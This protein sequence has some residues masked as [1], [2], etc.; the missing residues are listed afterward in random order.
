LGRKKI[1]QHLSVYLG[2]NRVGTL[3]KQSNGAIEF[4]YLNEWVEK[5]Y[6]IS[7]SLPL[8]DKSFVGDRASF[9][10][11]NLLPDNKLIVDAIAKKVGAISTQQFDLLSAIGR[12]CVGAL[13]FF[14]PEEVPVYTNKMSVRL[15]K[16][17]DI[18]QR[19]RGLTTDTPLGMEDGDFRLSLAGVQEKMALL[20][21]KGKWFEPRGQTATSHILKKKMGILAGGISFEKSVDNEWSCLFLAKQVGIK[22]CNAEIVYFEDQRVLSVERFDRVWKDNFLYR[23]PQEDLCQA[24]GISPQLKYERSGKG[25]SIFQIM[26]ILEH[27]NNAQEDRK[28]FFKTVLFNDLIYNT[29]GHAKNFSIYLTKRGFALTPMYDLL[30]AHFMAEKHADRYKKLR[31][32]LSVNGK[33]IFREI[34]LKD[35]KAESEKCDLSSDIFEEICHELNQAVKKMDT[36]SHLPPEMDRVEFKAIVKGIRSRCQVLFLD[37]AFL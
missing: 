32:S 5:G 4:R 1:I 30:S 29:D 14:P 21:R 2:K 8:E 34:T 15:L 10:F 33:Y 36:T 6:S 24:L 12:D 16:E 20:Y 35:W 13:S 28:M 22:T 26:K 25:P 9:Y 18:A 19:I 3:I 23:V 7:L 31:S 17:S 27:S 37:T 11:D